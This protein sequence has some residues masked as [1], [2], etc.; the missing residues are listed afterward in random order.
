[1]ETLRDT[2]WAV[3]A[4]TRMADKY[5]FKRSLEQL[6]K[7][8]PCQGKRRRTT[9]DDFKHHEEMQDGLAPAET[10]P[11]AGAAKD[12]NVEFKHH[13]EMRA[14][15]AC[16]TLLKVYLQVYYPL[17]EVRMLS[18]AW[19]APM[20]TV[21]V[22]NSIRWPDDFGM[23]PGFWHVQQVLQTGPWVEIFRA[24]GPGEQPEEGKHFKC[25]ADRTWLPDNI[26]P[27]NGRCHR[28]GKTKIG[29]AGRSWIVV[30]RTN[31][32]ESIEEE[33]LPPLENVD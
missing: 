11:L 32:T 19:V 27:A 7:R 23:T 3:S 14:R 30:K 21:R 15:E 24:P 18:G 4:G 5:Q 28:P 9:K 20:D 12:T 6:S 31:G 8:S 25:F 22:A 17:V 26:V 29:T 2:S 33:V 13:E 16:Q 10:Q 1:M